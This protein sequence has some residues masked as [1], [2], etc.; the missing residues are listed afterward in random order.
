MGVLGWMTIRRSRVKQSDLKTFGAHSP[1][2][3]KHNYYSP[4]GSLLIVQHSIDTLH[5]A[6]YYGRRDKW[7][8]VG[9]KVPYKENE[10]NVRRN[11]YCPAC[12]SYLW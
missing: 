12:L 9:M 4:G 1:R 8:I 6:D 7:A 3:Q 11:F 2:E 5:L 10:G